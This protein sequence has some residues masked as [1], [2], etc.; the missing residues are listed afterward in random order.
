MLLLALWLACDG[1]TTP[2]PADDSSISTDDSADDSADDTGDSEDTQPPTNPGVLMLA[3]GGS[4]GEREDQ[5][6][7]S[8]ALY[9]GLLS[10]G[11]INGD[12]Q[13]VVAVLSDTDETDW[14]PNYFVLLGADSAFNLKIDS[15]QTAQNDRT[16]QRISGADAVFLKGGD[17]GIYY[18]LWNDTATEAAIL[19]LWSRGG[20]VGGTSAGAMSQSEYCLSGSADYVSADVLTDSHTVYLD[21]VSEPGTSG[22]H[23]DFLNLLGGAY[24]DTHFTERGRLGRLLGVM[25]RAIDEGAP[26]SLVGIGLEQQTGLLV[27]GRVAQV[28]GVG[29]VSLVHASASPVREPGKGLVWT[30]LRLD[31]LTAGAS[32]DLDSGE[33]DPG[34][35]AEAITGQTPAGPAPAD[36]SAHGQDA[37]DAERFAWVVSSAP[38]STRAGSADPT[39]PASF[40]LLDAHNRDT[41]GLSQELCLRGLFEHPGALCA[42]VGEDGVLR[43]DSGLIGAAGADGDPE[44]SAILIDSSAATFRALSPDIS[45]YDAGDGSLHAA[46]LTGLTVQVLARSESLGLWYDPASRSV[47]SR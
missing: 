29:T 42:L 9:Q 31:V 13:V 7:W 30:D 23:T 47:S 34:P 10:G 44:Q 6:A 21:D 3:G 33:L 28:Y 36:W 27:Q 39:L 45:P 32:F 26:Q 41:R 5:S 15:R 37:D 14:I 18:D 2:P 35:N 12:G 46:G 38:Y 11:D 8:W 16:A 4:E 43:S 17:Q 22:V 25:A 40:G 19:D 24:V 1:K 20:G